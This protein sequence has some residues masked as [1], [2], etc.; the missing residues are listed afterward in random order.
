M[1]AALLWLAASFAYLTRQQD[2]P[3]M[4]MAGAAQIVMDQMPDRPGMTHAAEGDTVNPPHAPAHDHAGHCPFCF[5]AA[6]ALE[7]LAFGVP[8]FSPDC[9]EPPVPE[10]LAAPRV[11][12]FHKDARAPPV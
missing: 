1:L 4:T 7:S 9:A 11:P 2:M 3:G 12:A 10:R 8:F 6:F 5:T